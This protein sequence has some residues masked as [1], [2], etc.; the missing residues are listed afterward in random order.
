MDTDTGTLRFRAAQAADTPHVVDLVNSAYRGNSSRGGW[1][2]EANL[3]GGQRTDPDMVAELLAKP[4]T[5]LLLAESGGELAACCELRR[6]GDGDAYFG[7]LCVRPTMQGTG[8][9][10]AVLRRAERLAVRWWRARRMRMTVIRQ[11]EELVSWYERRGYERT[12]VTAPFPYGDERFGVPQRPDL[13]FT[14]LARTLPP[15][16]EDASPGEER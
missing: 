2:T 11:R 5:T 13:E 9:G 8:L 15:A 3:L 10:R 7:M 1:T 12:G 6:S 4:D 16:G 14:E